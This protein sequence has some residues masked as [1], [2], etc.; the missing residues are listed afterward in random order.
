MGEIFD[1]FDFFDQTPIL[2]L[3][4]EW[5]VWTLVIFLTILTIA[6]SVAKYKLGQAGYESLKEHYPQVE[7]E[8]WDRVDG[9][10]DRWGA[11]V[12][13][14]SFLPL[15]AWIIPP[16]AGAYGIKMRSFLFWAFLAK[17]VRYWLLIIIVVGV[18]ELIS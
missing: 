2:D 15:L 4:T 17:M 6:F 14:F 18:Y 9:Y 3:F 12:I 10:F 1:F 11:P 8:R 16:A 13:I 7:E 5:K